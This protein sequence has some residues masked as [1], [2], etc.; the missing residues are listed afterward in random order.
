[1][2][3]SH[4]IK[5]TALLTSLLCVFLISVDAKNAFPF[6][7]C[8]QQWRNLNKNCE[9]YF[10]SSQTPTK[11]SR[12][13]NSLQRH[14]GIPNLD[15]WDDE[16]DGEWDCSNYSQPILQGTMRESKVGELEY[17]RLSRAGWRTG[18]LESWDP[19]LTYARV[20]T[21]LVVE[22]Y[23]HQSCKGCQPLEVKKLAYLVRT[24]KKYF[25]N[26]FL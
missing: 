14:D 23:L 18:R 6:P 13:D 1:M 25:L 9:A 7:D 16:E 4:I 21:L 3:N 5:C 26:N 11:L 8:L 10:N 17:N 2:A 24:L 15:D 12:S 19:R 20:Y 22:L